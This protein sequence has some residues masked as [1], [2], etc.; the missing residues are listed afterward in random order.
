MH[1]QT[2]PPGFLVQRFNDG[3]GD[4][5]RPDGTGPGYGSATERLIYLTSHLRTNL[6]L[7]SATPDQFPVIRNWTMNLSVAR[8][9]L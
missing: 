5:D 8:K 6:E 2:I 4:Q 9:S 3:Y 7:K 1:Y